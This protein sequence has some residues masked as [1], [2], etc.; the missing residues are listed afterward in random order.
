VIYL[1]SFRLA[2]ESDETDYILDARKSY[3]LDMACHDMNNSYPFKIFPFKYLSR[4]D[5]APITLLYGGNG[6]GK[7]TLLNIIAQKLKLRRTSPYS[8]TPFFEDYLAYCRAELYREKNPPEGSCIIT[9]DDVFDYMLSFRTLNAGV[10]RDRE[11]LIEEWR[12]LRRGGFQMRSLEDFEEL[13]KRR[14][15]WSSTRSEYTARRLPKNLPGQSNGENAYGYFA[16]KIRGNALYLLD[17][18]ENSLSAERQTELAAFLEDS[19]RFYGC[20]FIISTHSPFLL[21]MKGARIYDL[22]EIP[23]TVKKWTELS[24]VRRYHEF[25]EKHR[26]EFESDES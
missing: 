8:R 1:E 12:D 13:Q 26:M 18:P 15:A 24:N 2:T 20:Q 4:L 6:S 5:F 22:D 21:A 17:E 14:E 11:A 9:S 7:S 10:D 23:V 19:A 16:E 25:F 3:K